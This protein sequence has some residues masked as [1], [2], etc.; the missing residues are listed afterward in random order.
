M[1]KLTIVAAQI[2]IVIFVAIITEVLPMGQVPAAL[3]M[4]TH[5]IFLQTL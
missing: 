5:L 2:Y 3:H 1:Q 4:L